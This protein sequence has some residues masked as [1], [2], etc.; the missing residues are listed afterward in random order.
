MIQVSIENT[1]I[2]VPSVARPCSSACSTS[3]LSRSF[4]SSSKTLSNVPGGST[5]SGC[6]SSYKA[7][8]PSP[9]EFHSPPPLLL[10]PSTAPLHPQ[11]HPQLEHF[12]Y[13]S[14][15]RVSSTSR[16]VA[17]VIV[18]CHVGVCINHTTLLIHPFPL[19]RVRFRE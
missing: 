1:M 17:F 7:N 10:P 8:S 16:V 12:R 6:E 19:H 14:P 4:T 9:N 15:A 11:P 3:P 18:V 2:C 5:T 13:L